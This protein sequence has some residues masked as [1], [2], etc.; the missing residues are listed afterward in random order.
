MGYNRAKKDMKKNLLIVIVT[1]V[2]MAFAIS[3][4][5]MLSDPSFQDGFRQGWNST[6]P[7]GYEY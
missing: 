3:S 5:A 2:L 1:T 4:C 7:P 6:C